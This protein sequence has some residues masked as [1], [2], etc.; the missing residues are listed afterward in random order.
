MIDSHAHLD[1][2]KFGE[3]QSEVIARA[4]ARGVE[5]IINVGAGLGSSYR[6][7][8]LAERYAD[9]FAAVGLHPHYF[10]KY[11]EGSFDRIEEFRELARQKK[12]VAI[13]EIGLDYFSHTEN[14]ITVEQRE[15]QKRGFIAQIEMARNLKLPV[16]IHCRSTGNDLSED[17]YI[18]TL[19]IIRIY[20]EINFVFHCYGGNLTFTGKLLQLKNIQFSFTGN[21]TYAKTGVEIIEVIKAIPLNKIMLET[22]C[23]YLTPVP[24]RGKRNEPAYVIFVQEKI[25]EIKEISASEVDRITTEN[26]I[27]F[28]KLN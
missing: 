10:N 11:G 24:H 18:D 12:V 27:E 14:P 17:A 28:Y 15:I 2:E 4:F 7:V 16:I 9:I 25:A 3:D 19:E 8:A 6:S 13:G 5:K 1:D 23:P 21:I 26:A 22:D 20:P